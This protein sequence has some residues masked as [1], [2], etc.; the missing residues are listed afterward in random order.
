MKPS[1]TMKMQSFVCSCITALIFLIPNFKASSQL[2]IS[3]G[4]DGGGV[5][6]TE[7]QAEQVFD[8]FFFGSGQSVGG[9]NLRIQIGETGQ[10]APEIQSLDLIG[11][12][13]STTF[14]TGNNQGQI[15][16]YSSNNQSAEGSVTTSDAEPTFISAPSDP[17]TFARV[18][19]DGTG[20]SAGQTFQVYFENILG[21]SLLDTQILD[22]SG[23][24]IST[25][26]GSSSITFTPV[27][28]PKDGILLIGLF[29]VAWS[30]QQSRK[31]TQ[32]ASDRG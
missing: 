15:L 25:S 5:S 32:S 3:L 13:S 11:S 21:N 8:I 10:D 9:A 12:V 31:A 19:V 6:L 30:Y 28:E 7:N 1:S 27:P 26:F 18:T 22:P 24:E 29:L 17:V 14:W 20:F 4:G 2:T 16:T 23:V